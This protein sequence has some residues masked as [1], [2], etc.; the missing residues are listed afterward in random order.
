LF[1]LCR[2]MPEK[3]AGLASVCCCN[4]PR[5]KQADAAV[6]KVNTRLSRE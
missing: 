2:P 4:T 5:I 6:G 3:P 1:P